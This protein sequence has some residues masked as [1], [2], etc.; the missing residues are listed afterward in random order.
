MAYFKCPL[1][2]MFLTR[3]L[4]SGLQDAAGHV[5]TET[6]LEHLVFIQYCESIAEVNHDL[7]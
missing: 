5:M 2:S 7:K 4:P 1:L 6:E 3:M